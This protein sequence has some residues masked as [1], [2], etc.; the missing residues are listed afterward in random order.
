VAE[1]D[2]K[3]S[4]RILSNPFFRFFIVICAF[5]VYI[6]LFQ[7][8]HSWWRVW[9]ELL[10]LLPL[11]SAAIG[12]GLWGGVCVGLLSVPLN[13]VLLYLLDDLYYG[14]SEIRIIAWVIILLSGIAVGLLRRNIDRLNGKID[15]HEERWRH[16]KRDERK[17]HL[18]YQCAPAAYQW[19]D[20]YGRII[21]ANPLCL[22]LMGYSLKEVI[23]RWFGNF[24]AEESQEEFKTR[25][26]VLLRS[27]RSFTMRLKL[28]RRNGNA[29]L[30]RL[31]GNVWSDGE[32]DSRSVYC[33]LR[34]I[35]RRSSILDSIRGRLQ[36]MQKKIER[37]R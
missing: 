18:L 4:Q 31:E 35:S 23:S 24:L 27:S 5:A 17:Y 1:I 2:K 28:L 21:E 3:P 15:V 32:D 10:I 37:S 19:L 14:L 36:E 26:P 7:L 11:L 20:E 34:D 22:K 9:S 30:I 13:S 33:I 25:L 16:A 8:F 29:R 6:F 12:F